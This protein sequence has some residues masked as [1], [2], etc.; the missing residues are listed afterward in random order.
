VR[1]AVAPA[2]LLLALAVPGCGSDAGSAD[3]GP[4]KVGL[5]VSLT[6]NYQALGT[7]DQKGAQIA[8]DEVNGAGG[9]NGRPIELLVKDDKTVPEQSVLAF[10]DHRTNGAVA[11][12]GSSFSNSGL[13]TIPQAERNRMP[14][15]SLAASDAQVDPVKPYAFQV[16]AKS[17]TYAERTLQYFKDTG[18]TRIALAWDT[19][20]SYAGAGHDATRRLAAD[21]GVQVVADQPFD[22]GTQN[23]SPVFEPVRSS[24]AQVLFA[25]LTGPPA[26]ILSQQF[27]S[28]GLRIPLVLT[29]AQGTQLYTK[30]AGKAA[31]GVVLTTSIGVIGRSLPDSDLK[32]KVDSFAAAYQ[33]KYGEYPPQFAFDGYAG[34]VLLAEALRKAGSTKAEDIR[35]ALEGLTLLTANGRYSYTKDDHSGLT[36][37][38]VA[39]TVVKG[40][41]FTPVP[42][43]TEQLT[44]KLPK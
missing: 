28:A 26:V 30:P 27:A 14:Y 15:L 24:G 23:F 3:S 1:R 31:E 12:I 22:T 42:W 10:N 37:D 19:R 2:A 34:V 43:M 8:L 6:G 38:N 41:E 40:G 4:I 7:G 33:A 5:T 25:W 44:K 13:A 18:V 17:S 32:R 21:Y 16:P 9:I 11:V 36:P 29:G 39:V 35:A 20:S